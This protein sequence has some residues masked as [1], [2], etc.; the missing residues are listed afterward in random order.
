[1]TKL[2]SLC[3]GVLPHLLLFCS[4]TVYAQV[5]VVTQH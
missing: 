5:N 3:R 2:P 1:M 4:L